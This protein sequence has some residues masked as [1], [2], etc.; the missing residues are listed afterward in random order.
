MNFY[1][2][3]DS[4]INLF[5]DFLFLGGLYLSLKLKFKPNT[6]SFF[7]SLPEWFKII[8]IYSL[9]IFVISSLPTFSS[10]LFI[11]YS[12]ILF[13]VALPSYLIYLTF[14][15]KKLFIVLPIFLILLIKIEAEVI[16]P[17]NIE[18]SFIHFRSDKINSKIKIVHLSDLHLDENSNLSTSIK[19][20]Q[21]FQPDLILITGDFLNDDRFTNYILDFFKNHYSASVFLV[22]G[23]HDSH[24]NWQT[25]TKL[26][27]VKMLSNQNTKLLIQN[28]LI[29]IVGIKNKSFKDQKNLDSL[30]P[31]TKDKQFNI[32]LSHRPDIVYLDHIEI[33]DLVFTG[34]THGGQ[35]NLPW[36]GALTTVSKIPN[37]IAK[38]GL[39]AFRGT[40]LVSNRG[41]GMEGHVAP[42][43]RFLCQPQ[44]IFLTMD[45]KEKN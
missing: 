26:D 45:P 25:L 11:R 39:F 8:G 16:E 41:L 12:W 43:I 22:D 10:F 18:T 2:N 1:W 24:L 23:D 30:L 4:V 31:N 28:Q 20:I 33:F 14:K 36:V 37:Y 13:T 9:I 7:D 6:D 29:N 34:H 38:G 21:S 3:Q 27:H 42:R 35:F 32:L 17:K 40:N 15:T 19:E 44:M 5:L